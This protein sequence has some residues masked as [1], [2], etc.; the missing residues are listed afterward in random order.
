MFVRIASF[1]I[2]HIVSGL[3]YSFIELL[4]PIRIILDLIIYITGHAMA[5]TPSKAE[6]T[7]LVFALGADHRLASMV[8]LDVH[9][10]LRTGLRVF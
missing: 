5:V 3:V 2:W 10:A 6:P 1:L 4:Q 7:E 8:L 9:M